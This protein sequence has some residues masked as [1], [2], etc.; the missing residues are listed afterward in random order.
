[1][2]QQYHK[3]DLPVKFPRL[4]VQLVGRTE[5][6]KKSKCKFRFI[7]NRDPSYKAGVRGDVVTFGVFTKL[8][9]QS[10][11]IKLFIDS[12]LE[13]FCMCLVKPDLNCISKGILE[14]F[15]LV[16][17]LHVSRALI[18][19]WFSPKFPIKLNKKC[20]FWV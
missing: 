14:L 20:T 2:Q 5:Y 19:S 1:M 11:F 15:C 13:S 4:L 9:S 10:L 17:Y 16:P 12:I 7:F 8:F 6:T 3:T 18:A